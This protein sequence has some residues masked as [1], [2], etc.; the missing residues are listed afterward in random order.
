MSSLES[1][2]MVPTLTMLGLVSEWIWLLSNGWGRSHA[3]IIARD[4]AARRGV[5]N[6]RVSAHPAHRPGGSA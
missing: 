5:A 4:Q 1:H 2:T 6:R 3:V